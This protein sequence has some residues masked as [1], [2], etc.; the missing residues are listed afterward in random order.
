MG[1]SVYA[2]QNQCNMTGLERLVKSQTMPDG[3]HIRLFLDHKGKYRIVAFKSRAH[4]VGYSGVLVQA[5]GEIH[6]K[7]TCQSMRHHGTTR[8]LQSMLT[9]WGVRW[10][11]S[12]YQTTAGAATDLPE[13]LSTY[14]RH[15]NLDGAN[16]DV[17]RLNDYDFKC[18]RRSEADLP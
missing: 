4:K 10:Y 18:E 2:A 1:P 8:K 13:A 3:N 16:I 5:D 12:P 15:W 14:L 17:K 6:Y 11:R 9:V 7:E